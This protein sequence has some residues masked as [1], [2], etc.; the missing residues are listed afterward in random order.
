MTSHPALKDAIQ[1]WQI[2]LATTGETP[3]GS[4]QSGT[5]SESR[6]ARVALACQ[7]CKARKQKCDGVRPSC[8]KCDAQGAACAYVLPSNYMPFGKARY[9]KALEKRVADLESYSTETGRRDVGTDHWQYLPVEATSAS[10]STKSA[11]ATKALES[12]KSTKSTTSSTDKR[13]PSSNGVE[14][15]SSED[16]DADADADGDVDPDIHDDDVPSTS[17]P[18]PTSTR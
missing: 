9:V 5:A 18:P 7:R 12:T 15:S 4:S 8:A 3:G 16:A 1:S 10:T 17:P 11:T 13:P 6:R 14:V 2:T